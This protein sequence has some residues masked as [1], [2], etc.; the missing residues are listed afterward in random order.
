MD[1]KAARKGAAAEAS[2]EWRN[3]L[4]EFEK[5]NLWR[6]WP[7][8]AALRGL[9]RKLHSIIEAAP[10]NLLQQFDALDEAELTEAARGLMGHM[11]ARRRI[12]AEDDDG[13]ALRCAATMLR[14]LDEQLWET[15]DDLP[16]EAP[17]CWLTPDGEAYVVRAPRPVIR[18]GGPATGQSFSRRG[19]LYHRVIPRRIEDV[20][21][22]LAAHPDVT[23]EPA[24]ACRTFGAALF[25]GFRLEHEERPGKKFVVTAADC[26]GG[27][28]EAL[29]RHCDDAR[30][31]GCDTLLWPE[32][33]LPPD[34]VERLAERLSKSPLRTAAPPVVVAGSWHVETDE[35][36][37][38]L[39]PVLDGRGTTILSFGKSRRF[40]FGGL[41]EDIEVDGSVTIL[42]TD[43]ELIAFAI[44]KDF[45]DK[46]RSVPV[47]SLDVDLVLVPSMGRSNTMT[48]HR[49]AADDMKVRFGTR[50]AVVQ[51]TYPR[52]PPEPAGYVLPA[53]KEPRAKDVAAL[54]ADRDFTTFQPEE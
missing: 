41:T 48:A 45:C 34:K 26:D 9:L 3:R 35:G 36:R 10:A 40:S 37:F 53:P 44:C 7:R 28:D 25:E 23:E 27:V 4:S 8:P 46:A 19:L 1:R 39:A 6:N 43:R 17:D 20:E 16:L 5:D 54:E 29:G 42:V 21:I 24:P 12:A 18:G 14:S 30:D 51:Q 49:D 52:K 2:A 11:C 31:A 13:E 38:N 33:T 50:S 47:K 15:E 32:L 22:V